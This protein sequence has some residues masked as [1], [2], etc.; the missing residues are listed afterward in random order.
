[1]QE[2][3]DAVSRQQQARHVVFTGGEPML[4]KELIPLSE[5]LSTAG[6]HITIET[7]G[8]ILRGDVRCDLA[9][10]SPK[11]SNSTPLSGEIEQAWISRHEKTRLQPA[12]LKDW[13]QQGD[14]QLKFVVGS[15]E[16]IHE[17]D[18]L[19]ASIDVP[20][21]PHKVLLMPEG[22]TSAVLRGKSLALVALCK[23]R[24][25]RFSDRLHVHL[26]GQQRGT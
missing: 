12:V 6:W 16:D 5:M 7:A 2:V 22:V 10:I 20:V 18:A 8:T 24:G 11:L 23:E 21:A 9:S 1:V 14:Y 19:L 3:F 17:I 4:V 15:S 26:F 13:L 25:F